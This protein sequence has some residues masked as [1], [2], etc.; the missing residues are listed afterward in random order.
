MPTPPVKTAQHHRSDANSGVN[1]GGGTITVGVF[2]ERVDAAD[3]LWNQC[4]EPLGRHKQ[5]VL[6]PGN[7]DADHIFCFGTPWPGSGKLAIPSMKRRWAKFRGTL[8]TLRSE[9]AWAPFAGRPADQV[10]VLFGDPPPAVEQAYVDAAHTRTDR[11]FGPDK[12]V[13]NPIV[14]PVTYHQYEDVQHFRAM[15]RQEKTVPLVAITSGAAALP[16]HRERMAFLRK[17]RQA[18]VP[19]ELFGRKLPED[20]GGRGALLN[21]SAMLKPAAMALVIENFSEGDLYVTE[22]LW[23]SLMCWSLP[24]YYGSRA[25]EKLLP[26]EAYVRLPDLGEAGVQ[27]VKAALADRGLYARRLDAIAHARTRPLGDLRLVEW[28]SQSLSAGEG[29]ATWPPVMAGAA[30]GAVRS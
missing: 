15:P 23:D 4:D 1:G 8:S 24:L 26:P 2:V 10:T 16:G 20:L 7:V 17:L 12:R 3:A 9:M 5:L 21:K 14:L 27:T 29:G 25:I 13:K 18:G 28:L 19:F 22:K 11:V 30:A 6:Q